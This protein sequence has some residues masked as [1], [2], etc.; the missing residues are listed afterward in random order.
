MEG[1]FPLNPPPPPH[2]SRASY[3]TTLIKLILGLLRTPHAPKNFQ[4]VLWGEYH[5]YFLELHISSFFFF[6]LNNNNYKK[7]IM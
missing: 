4:S 1:I 2:L 7:G 5:G 6:F 3:I